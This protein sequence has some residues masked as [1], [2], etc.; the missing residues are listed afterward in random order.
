MGISNGHSNTAKHIFLQ[1]RYINNKQDPNFKKL[2]QNLAILRPINHITIL[3]IL[4]FQLYL[5]KPST[6]SPI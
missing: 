5:P 2:R 1:K 4:I 6:A 3:N